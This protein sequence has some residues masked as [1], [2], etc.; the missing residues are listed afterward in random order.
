[1][2]EQNVLSNSNNQRKSETFEE[3]NRPA[4]KV[5]S[6]IGKC[7]LKLNYF[8]GKEKNEHFVLAWS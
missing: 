5:T 6:Q 4:Q 2:I 7:S 3:K 8:K 1:L